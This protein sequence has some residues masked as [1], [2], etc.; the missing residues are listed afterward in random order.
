MEFENNDVQFNAKNSFSSAVIDY[1]LVQFPRLG[2][3]EDLRLWELNITSQ[4]DMTLS[5]LNEKWLTFNLFLISHFV[6]V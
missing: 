3:D 6:I 4:L 2:V 5:D 1:G